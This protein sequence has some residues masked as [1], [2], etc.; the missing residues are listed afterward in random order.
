MSG[1]TSRWCPPSGV[2]LVY[3]SG[4]NQGNGEVTK[5]GNF[6]KIT[7]TGSTPTGDENKPFE[8]EVTCP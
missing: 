3:E 7:G 5:N 4:T 1:S 2:T 6:Y 8:I